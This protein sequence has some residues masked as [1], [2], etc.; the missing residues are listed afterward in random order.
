[1]LS[2]AHVRNL[3]AVLGLI[4]NF[5]KIHPDELDRVVIYGVESSLSVFSDAMKRMV[6][7][8]S[9]GADSNDMGTTKD[10]RGHGSQ[11]EKG[12]SHP[13]ET[14]QENTGSRTEK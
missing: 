11:K 7:V 4:E 6:P 5:V 8:G 14:Q 1:M 13:E 9:E 10:F 2:Y 12:K 3:Q